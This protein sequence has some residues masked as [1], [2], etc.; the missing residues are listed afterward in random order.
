MLFFRVCFFLCSLYYGHISEKSMYFH[1]K[2]SNSRFHSSVVFALLVGDL[3]CT[4]LLATS[5]VSLC[6][7]TIILILW[8]RHTLTESNM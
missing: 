2:P 5:N 7:P 1:F 3:M 6:G 8:V 4:C